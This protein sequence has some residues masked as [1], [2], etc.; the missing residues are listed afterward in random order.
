M[1]KFFLIALASLVLVF[2]FSAAEAEPRS[3]TVSG[4]GNIRFPPDMA[5]FTVGAITEASTAGVAFKNASAAGKKILAAVMSGFSIPRDNV[6]TRE[7]TVHPV[8]GKRGR[9]TKVPQITGY[10][11]THRIEIRVGDLDIL[12]RLFDALVKNGANTFSGLSFFIKEAAAQKDEAL[13]KAFADAK[14]KAHI[15]ATAA[16]KK[17]GRVLQ[18]EEQGADPVRPQM[19]SFQAVERSGVSPGTIEVKASVRVVFEFA[20]GP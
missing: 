19:M 15:L 20:D 7:V 13:K 2:S 10:R 11:A 12:G 6:Q 18:I 4:S 16:G 8:Y 14:R 17:I 5:R 9:N 1:S 3:I